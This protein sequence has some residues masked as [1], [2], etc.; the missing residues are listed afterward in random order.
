MGTSAQFHIVGSSNHDCQ[1]CT[2]PFWPRS[3]PNRNLNGL[4]PMSILQFAELPM[5]T[6][7]SKIASLK[8]NA[9]AQRLMS[10]VRSLPMRPN[11][12]KSFQDIA[13]MESLPP[14]KS[15]KPQLLFLLRKE[16]LIPTP[17]TM[18]FPMLIMWHQ[19]PPP[20]PSNIIAKM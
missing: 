3:M 9:F 15:Q 6:L 1:G 10:K 14:Q 18:A 20:S 7:S 8:L 5:M 16:M 11:V 17:F 4:F 19:Q 12:K 13:P 2:F